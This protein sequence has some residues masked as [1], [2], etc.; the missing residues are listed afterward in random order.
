MKKNAIFIFKKIQI[1]RRTKKNILLL[2]TRFSFFT[3]F[4]KIKNKKK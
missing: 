3:L 1:K 4:L 2:Q